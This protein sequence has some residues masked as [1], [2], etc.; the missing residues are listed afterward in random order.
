V[1]RKA[2]TAE[3]ADLLSP[4]E[5]EVMA[6]V[7]RHPRINVGD[8]TAVVNA[9][10]ARKLSERTVATILRRLDAK[11]YATHVV[12]GRAFLYTA[13]VPE[14]QFV[15]W[16]GRRA[17]GEFLGRYGPE[18][19]VAGLVE[20]SGAGRAALDLLEELLRRYREDAGKV[21]T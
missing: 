14:D 9:K 1:Q 19:A 15:A 12:D 21:A 16:H 10:R 13:V 5:A 7:W 8:A 20:A 18:V 11:G 17:M 6:V 2:K 3:P 4:L